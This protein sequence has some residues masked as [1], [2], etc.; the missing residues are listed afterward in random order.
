M[1]FVCP[2][3]F[4]INVSDEQVDASILDYFFIPNK[5]YMFRV[6]SSLTIISTWLYLQNLILST[7]FYRLGS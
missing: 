5:L 7:G 3:I 4:G 6:K 1:T 2:C